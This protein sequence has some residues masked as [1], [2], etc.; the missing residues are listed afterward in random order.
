VGTV[1]VFIIAAFLYVGVMASVGDL[2]RSDAA[3]RGLAIGYGAVFG[4]GLWLALAILVLLAYVGGAMPRWV[5]A[6][7]AVLLPLAGIAT[8]FAAALYAETGG[9]PILV[10]ALLPPIVALYALALR[11]PAFAAPAQ[12]NTI[13]VGA[14]LVL[15]VVP[16]AVSYG[17]SH[18]GADELARRQAAAQAAQVAREQEERDARTREIAAFKAL[19]PDSSLRDYL[20]YLAPG[21]SRFKEA[22][23]GARLVKSRQTDA[24]ALLREG[25]LLHLQELWRLDLAPTAE[26]CGAYAIALG[27]EAMKVERG[28][29][30]YLALAMDLERQLPNIR[31]LAGA[32]CDLD[33]ALTTLETNLRA[34]SDSER[35]SKFADTVRSYRKAP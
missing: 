32:A 3:G 35:L 7:M 6:A 29:G 27:A 34:V 25:K 19:D 4:L 12:V 2:Q 30:A 9:W 14:V 24:V 21:D 13:A 31:W 5:A 11:I 26:L 8:V 15:S 10:P 22:V 28:R 23:A 16:L 1:I 33:A 17:R 20:D 18:P